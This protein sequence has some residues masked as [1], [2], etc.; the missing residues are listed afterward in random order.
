MTPEQVGL[1]AES[2][3]AVAGRR[4]EIARMFYQVLFERHPEL[5]PLFTRTDM[6]AQYE[7]FAGMVDEIVQL[8]SAPREFVKSAVLLG[9]RHA[10]YG[11]TRDQ[12]AP[13]GAVLLEVLAAALGPAFTPA[14]REAW[15]EG[16]LLTSSIMSRAAEGTQQRR[17]S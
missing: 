1:L 10:A 4:E 13:A 9:Q 15:S 11:V 12:Y 7:K 2:W 3:N 14:V 8:R 6:R 5:R 16:Y 17:A